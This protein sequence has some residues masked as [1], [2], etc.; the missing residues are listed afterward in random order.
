MMLRPRLWGKDEARYLYCAVQK[1]EH[2]CGFSGEIVKT[3]AAG[4][5]VPQQSKRDRFLH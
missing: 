5:G 2:E 1:C 3:R 4:D